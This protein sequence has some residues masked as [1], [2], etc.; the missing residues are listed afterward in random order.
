MIDPHEFDPLENPFEDMPEPS[1]FDLD[2]L[3]DILAGDY[4]WFDA[5]LFRLILKADGHNKERLR[6]VYPLHVKAFE[7]YRKG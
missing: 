7:D 5:Y 2:N 6:M 4:D 1:D 3:R